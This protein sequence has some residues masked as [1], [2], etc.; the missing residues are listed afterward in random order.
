M[1]QS[2]QPRY[3]IAGIETPAAAEIAQASG[4]LQPEAFDRGPRIGYLNFGSISG[5]RGQPAVLCLTSRRKRSGAVRAKQS[6]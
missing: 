5:S 6:C 3:S 4:V 2:C 1:P